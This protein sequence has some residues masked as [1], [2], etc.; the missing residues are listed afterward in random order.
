M[1]FLHRMSK[2]A[3]KRDG[4]NLVMNDKRLNAEND[5]LDIKDDKMKVEGV[6]SE[7]YYN[8]F[9]VPLV[10]GKQFINENFDPKGK[11]FV[12]LEDIESYKE[13]PVEF[14]R[15]YWDMQLVYM[16]KK[17][18]AYEKLEEEEESERS[19]KTADELLNLNN[20]RNKAKEQLDALFSILDNRQE[21]K[22]F[23]KAIDDF[24]EEVKKL[25][26]TYITQKQKAGE[27][28]TFDLEEIARDYSKTVI[29][30][31]NRF[32]DSEDDESKVGLMYEEQKELDELSAKLKEIDNKIKT[33]REKQTEA[34]KENPDYNSPKLEEL[35]AEK[36]PI[37][38]SKER[39][40][41]DRKQ[42][43]IFTTKIFRH[44]R[45]IPISPQD[46]ERIV[47]G[48]LEP[49]VNQKMAD[50]IEG[51]LES[52]ISYPELT[53]PIRDAF[54]QHFKSSKKEIESLV[55]TDP[56]EREQYLKDKKPKT[57]QE[58]YKIST[59][60]MEQMEDEFEDLLKVFKTKNKLVDLSKFNITIGS[61]TDDKGRGFEAIL[62][63]EVLGEELSKMADFT[64]IYDKYIKNLQRLEEIH[65]K[66]IKKLEDSKKEKTKE[67]K[68]YESLAIQTIP[69][70]QGD[71][72]E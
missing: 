12:G 9:N 33:E 21:G 18:K 52:N 2:S 7:K 22:Q 42:Q 45:P 20:P 65:N 55:P 48:A 40:E 14:V 28:D 10:T 15:L 51:L 46:G 44:I 3:E 58:Q 69:K 54:L 29:Q 23:F 62:A 59:A 16:E 72:E 39:I 36:K 47:M 6:T 13:N 30:R 68:E 67:Q 66:N 41:A 17:Q 19:D 31:M 71:E 61:K 27:T 1:K 56:K 63:D 32:L 24:V 64:D 60:I 37:K 70:E 50:S 57:R 11:S 43:K 49:L 38:T 8:I 5:T 26:S 35:L 4:S 25:Q 34:R 53:K